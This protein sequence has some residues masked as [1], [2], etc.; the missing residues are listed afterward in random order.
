MH[1]DFNARKDTLH[2]SV[3]WKNP[4]QKSNT[5]DGNS[6]ANTPMVKHNYSVLL[7][8]FKVT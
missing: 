2:N 8:K 3:G 7:Y 5:A 4:L 6:A 1:G